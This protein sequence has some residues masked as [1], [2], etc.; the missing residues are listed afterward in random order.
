[1]I[2]NVKIDT[3]LENAEVNMNL[4]RQDRIKE[5]LEKKSVATIKE[6]QALFPDVSLMTIHRDLNALEELGVITKHHGMVKFVRFL[7]DVDFGVRMGENT[8]GK[9][10]MVKKA[11]PL[12]QPHS[13]VF[14]DAGTSNLFLAKN[15]PDISLNVVTTSPSI[16][17]ELCKL[18]NPN[19]T[20]C[21][22]TMN[23]RNMSVS[24]QN[25]IEMLKKINID[26]AFIGVSGYSEKA[27]FTCGT[28]SD[29]LIKR[30]VIEKARVTVMMCGN[31]KLDRLMPYT[32]GDIGDADYFITDGKMSDSVVHRAQKAGTILL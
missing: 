32:F 2:K 14:L 12:L 26:I 19:V 11:I 28:E 17:L 10:S 31:E 6:V 5:Y 18:H 9:L 20:L 3:M 13:S 21:C 7:D 22:G 29:M 30:T 27:G 24:G 23:R 16:A 25:T 1:M 4:L 15:L 8:P